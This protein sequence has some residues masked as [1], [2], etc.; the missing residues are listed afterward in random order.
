MMSLTSVMF[1]PMQQHAITNPEITRS[2]L[3]F[4]SIDEVNFGVM[5]SVRSLL[6]HL[7]TYVTCISNFLSYN[8][9]CI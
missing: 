4:Q 6:Y 5:M 1:A 3:I 8:Y 9:V 2:C 7:H